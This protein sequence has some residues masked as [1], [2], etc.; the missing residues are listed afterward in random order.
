MSRSEVQK[1]VL[2]DIF[3]APLVLFPILG[4]LTLSIFSWTFDLGFAFLGFLGVLGGLGIMASRLVFGLEK[5]TEEAYNYIIEEK[6]VK[7]QKDLDELDAKLVTNRDSRDQQALRHLRQMY[8]T[9]KEKIAAKGLD[10]EF[11]EK[12]ES[13]FEGCV[14]QL[15]YSYELWESARPLKGDSKYEI[16]DR[17]EVVLEEVQKSVDCFEKTIEEFQLL[18]R[19][20]PT[21]LSKLREELNESLEVK[22]QVQKRL[23]KLDSS[24][25]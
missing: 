8:E 16:L 2:L 20:K 24:N 6:K 23:A 25:P 5:L 4:G 10:S 3:A 21:E 11:G 22:K 15:V 14:E 7:R 12:L 9:Y 1:K 17:R 19:D 18:R 13:L